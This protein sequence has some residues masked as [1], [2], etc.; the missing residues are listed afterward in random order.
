MTTG[1]AQPLAPTALV[2]LALVALPLVALVLGA[3]QAI[4]H[5]RAPAGAV[6]DAEPHRA[7]AVLE[8]S[9]RGRH[10]DGRGRRLAHRHREGV[11]GGDEPD[12][13]GRLAL[14]ERGLLLADSIFA[15]WRLD[16]SPG[17][18]VAAALPLAANQR[19]STA[20]ASA[21]RAGVSAS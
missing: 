21:R 7:P 8:R 19:S 6:A 5:H 14:S 17:G 12:R 9:A 4:G 20:M 2:S 18:A 3:Q 15:A 10:E 11:L 1:Q 13:G 16:E